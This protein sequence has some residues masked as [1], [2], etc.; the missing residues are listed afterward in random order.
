MTCDYMRENLYWRFESGVDYDLMFNKLASKMSFLINF[1]FTC[2][3]YNC[4]SVD[5]SGEI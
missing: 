2:I 4:K 1:I 3:Y 5:E